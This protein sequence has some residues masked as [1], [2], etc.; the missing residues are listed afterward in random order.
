[1]HIPQEDT[2]PCEAATHVQW[3]ENEVT[4]KTPPDVISEAGRDFF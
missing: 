3:R 2:L 1:M 4:G